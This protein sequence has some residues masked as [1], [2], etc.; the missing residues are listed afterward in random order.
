MIDQVL[1]YL[2]EAKTNIEEQFH[3]WFEFASDIAKSTGVS[4]S[5]SRIAKCWS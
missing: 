1:N 3:H 4:P 5:N 2:T